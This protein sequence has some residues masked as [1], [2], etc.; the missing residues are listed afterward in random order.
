MSSTEFEQLILERMSRFR[1]LLDNA[2]F[3][4]KQHQYDGVEWC[5]RNEQ[6]PKPIGNVRGGFIADE[7]GLGKTLLMIGTM[8]CNFL[9]HTL[10]VVPPVLIQQWHRE[11]F[12]VT[13]HKALL[14]YGTNKKKIIISQLLDNTSPIVLTTYSTL[15]KKDCLLKKITW[16]RV[17]FDE[18]HHLRN[19]KTARFSS[20]KEIKA[21]CRWI[22]TGTPIQNKKKDFYNLCC[23][24]G[25]TTSF[26]MNINNLPLINFKYF[27]KKPLY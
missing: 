5:I 22:V 9:S 2:H 24:A 18:A 26:Y 12:R 19:D 8:F 23:A 1:Y 3:E 7:M 16:N 21:R 17:I 6:Q 15:L 25:M 13:G 20:C 11:I 14:F 4:F 27:F 10:I